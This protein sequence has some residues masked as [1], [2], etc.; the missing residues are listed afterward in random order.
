MSYD[1]NY[2][3]PQHYDEW[4]ERRSRVDGSHRASHPR[5]FH[6]DKDDDYDNNNYNNA[7]H[8]P[9][10]RLDF[11][12]SSSQPMSQ[13][14]QS[15]SQSQ[16]QG[17]LA[18]FSQSP[19]QQ[20]QRSVLHPTE[21][22]A[23][24]Q[25]WSREQERQHRQD[26]SEASSQQQMVL[27]ESRDR[28]RRETHAYPSQRYDD[29]E[30]GWQTTN[31]HRQSLFDDKDDDRPSIHQQQQQH[32]CA[33]EASQTSTSD[34]AVDR[35]RKQQR[36]FR[37]SQ[38]KNANTTT[39][40][41]MLS[42]EDVIRRVE[43]LAQSVVKALANDEL[44]ELTTLTMDAFV[45]SN[46]NDSDSENDSDK[47]DSEEEDDDTDEDG[48]DDDNGGT[49]MRILRNP[50][51]SNEQVLPHR[52]IVF[53]NLSQSRKFS[54]ILLV[55]SFCHALLLAQRTTT[56][57]E[58]YYFYVTHFRTQRECDDAITDVTTLLRVP[59]SSLGL[60]ASPKGWYCGC[61]QILH[62]QT[63]R[64]V[65]DGQALS[66]VQGAPITQEWLQSKQQRDFDIDCRVV[67]RSS[68]ASADVDDN[69]SYDLHD[70][71]SE[72]APPPPQL[73]AKCILVI[74][75]EG[76][77]NRLSEDRL[78]ERYPCILVTGK[79][80]PDLATRSLV[81]TLHHELNLPVYGIADCNPYG[82]LVLQT[83]QYGSLSRGVDGGSR[84]SV[85]IQWLGLRP[86]HV[87]KFVAGSKKD[88][89]NSTNTAPTA[90][91]P[92]AV[93]QQLTELDEK[94]LEQL[95][96]EGH[97][98]HADAGASSDDRY[99]E[100]EVMKEN[101]YKVELEALNWLGTNCH[102]QFLF[103]SILSCVCWLRLHF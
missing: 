73:R 93:F 103:Q 91:L 7:F 88:S 42:C 75:K 83:Y 53:H 80:F 70:G 2:K 84:Y 54:S 77:Y 50:H 79:G 41:E 61:I 1:A 59:R 31:K 51:P 12:Q 63:G 97:K 95:L 29:D 35:S 74:E 11:S 16:S 4:E 10:H 94:R 101:G 56:T 39:T 100:L 28:R 60:F 89:Q 15:Q 96:G 9:V 87:E 92:P 57:R 27:E 86:S 45:R 3:N 34:E 99:E 55:L 32:Q 40:P 98:F 76:V 69:R 67:P 37:K 22:T 52:R 102:K 85:P 62:P 90:K 46:K 25:W 6:H 68:S 5:P 24:D 71:D 48:R 30:S 23:I 47:D 44:P 66:S 49:T 64:V 13:L 65:M 18:L 78:Y 33:Q 72:G 81:Y 17:G 8:P 58:V 38:Q 21:A 20:S 19:S 26:K 82:V 43:R 14:T 36:T